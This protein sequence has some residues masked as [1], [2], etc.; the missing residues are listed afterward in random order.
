MSWGEW[1]VVNMSMEEQLSLETQARAAL[2]HHDPAAVGRLC[3]ALIKQN[4]MQ[5]QLI[6]QAAGHIAKLEMEQFLSESQ[7]SVA[8]PGSAAG[9]VDG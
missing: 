1:M 3:S 9:P 4:A 6:R 7:S 8:P 2:H 5:A